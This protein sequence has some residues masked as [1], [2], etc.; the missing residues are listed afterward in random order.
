[1]SDPSS[2][3][4]SDLAIKLVLYLAIALFAAYVI[5]ELKML[6]LCLG[7]AVTLASAMAPVAEW[8]E[9][10]KISRIISVI[11]MY[12]LTAVVYVV[13]GAS[14]LPTLK[15]EGAHLYESLPAYI[16]KVSGWVDTGNS[17]LGI[18]KPSG[19]PT[20]S[21]TQA[22]TATDTGSAT[23]TETGSATDTGSATATD[24]G[25]ATATD[26]VSTNS[27]TDTGSAAA[28]DTGSEP[29]S[30]KSSPSKGK[31]TAAKI[32]NSLPIGKEE[33]K[34]FLS[35]A[36]EKSI[37]MTAGIIGLTANVVLTLFLAAYFVI[38]ADNLWAD[39]LK[40]IPPAH[41][42]RVKGLIRPFEYKLG[43]FVRG[44]LLV[45]FCVGLFLFAGF[46]LLRVENALML[47]MLA[48]LLNLVPYV[49]SLIATGS[50][51]L[52]ALNQEGGGPMLALAVFGLYALEQWVESS[53][54]VPNLLGKSVDLHPLIVLISI[55][56]GGSLLG[57]AGAL[58]AIPLAS[59]GILLSEEF[60][61]KPMEEAEAKQAD[62]VS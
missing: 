17:A 50:A 58:I 5:H 33:I 1:M 30:K 15:K 37:A 35:K 54:I 49:G 8:A 44:Q 29:T 55:I 57:I 53:F 42:E 62:S 21:N 13:L 22:S 40:W 51:L 46:S 9:K 4:N 19:T 48:A 60:Y 39:I 56:V 31:S 2:K 18:D 52:V 41:R 14:L 12:A 36:M 11:A 45:S 7:F 59:V 38:E 16:E 43:G 26:T 6:L 25:S 61:L 27:A 3:S 28:T 32:A 47:G 10:R 23:S 24:T 20:V 34:G